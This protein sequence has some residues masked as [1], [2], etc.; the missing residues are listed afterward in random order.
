MS[1]RVFAAAVVGAAVLASGTVAHA[2]TVLDFETAGQFTGNFRKVSGPGNGAQTGP[3]AGNDYVNLAG[4][5]NFTSI[6][7]TTPADAAEQTVFSVAQGS[8]VS[9]TTDVRFTSATSSF[10]VYF[11]DPTNEANAYLALLNFDQTS[12]SELVRFASNGV[13]TTGG[14][15]TLVT[16]TPSPGD[17]V[18]SGQFA[19]ATFTYAIDAANHPV[20]SVTVGSATSSTTFDT[21]TSPLTTVELAIRD[22]AQGTGQNGFDNIAFPTPVPEP[23][24]LGM[25]GLGGLLLRRHRR[26]RPAR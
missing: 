20:L 4:T 9:V 5:S 23:T 17:V 18:A 15:G 19:T 2:V 12:S 16:G 21:I 3:A 26:R 25:L 10:G 6:Y 24:A 22:S 1:V 11:V 7:D 8:P 13:P 14:A